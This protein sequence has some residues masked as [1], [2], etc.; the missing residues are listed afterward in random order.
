MP[1][2]L[3]KLLKVFEE[4]MLYYNQTR[5]YSEKEQGSVENVDLLKQNAI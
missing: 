3:S 4:W 5:N 1:P 2:K